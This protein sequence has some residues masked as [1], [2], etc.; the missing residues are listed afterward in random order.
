MSKAKNNNLFEYKGNKTRAATLSVIFEKKKVDAPVE[1]SYTFL[2]LRN[3][4][5]K[6]EF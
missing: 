2:N 3:K 1:R 4:Q 6:I 5:K